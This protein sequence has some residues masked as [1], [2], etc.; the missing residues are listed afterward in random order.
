MPNSTTTVSACKDA[1]TQL[2][3]CMEKSPCVQKGETIVNCMQKGDVGTCEV[4]YYYHSIILL[5][6]LCVYTYL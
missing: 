6:D 3:L 4:S 2:A 1:A 5:L